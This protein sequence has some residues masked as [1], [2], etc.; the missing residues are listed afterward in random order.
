[1]NIE[2]GEHPMR[3]EMRKVGV[4]FG[5]L[6]EEQ[7]IFS[8]EKGK[9][10][11]IEL[12]NYFKDGKD[13]WEIYCLKGNLFDDIERFCTQKKAIERIYELL[14]ENP[15]RKQRLLLE[16]GFFNRFIFF[17]KKKVMKE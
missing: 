8:S 17:I 5:I 1:M 3:R 10:S 15:N 16:T 9:I 12:P 2:K 7:Q 6:G 11:L 14:E 4:S 13:L